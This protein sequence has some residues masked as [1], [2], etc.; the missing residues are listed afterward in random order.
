MEMFKFTKD[1]L[2]KNC[3]C[4]EGVMEKLLADGWVLI[5]DKEP[6]IEVLEKEIKPAVKKSIKKKA[7][8]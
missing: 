7:K 6:E 2:E 4:H 5:S 3:H 1:G 8:K